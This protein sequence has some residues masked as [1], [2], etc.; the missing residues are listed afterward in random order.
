MKKVKS[1]LC[2]LIAVALM[3]TLFA[4]SKDNP[5]P[6]NNAGSDPGTTGS[7]PPAQQQ[8]QQPDGDDFV[9]LVLGVGGYLGIFLPGVSPTENKPACSGVFDTVFY[10]D[11]VKEEFYSNILSDWHYEDPVTLVMT[12]KTGIMFSNGTEATPADLLFSYTSNNERGSAWFSMLPVDWENCILRDD[13]TVQIKTFAPCPALLEQPAYLISESW[14]REVGWD[15]QEWYY[16]VGSGPYFCYDYLADDHITLRLRD[17][18]WNAANTSFVVD[19]WVIK[20]YPDPTSLDMDFEQGNIDITRVSMQG[21][22]RFL[23]DGGKGIDCR[24]MDMGTISFF[25]MDNAANP[26]FDDIAVRKAIAHA[27]DWE[28]LGYQRIGESMYLPANSFAVP[29]T[30]YNNTSVTKYE[31]DPDLAKSFLNEA[32]YA[33]GE[34][35]INVYTM[36]NEGYK[37]FFVAMQYYLD[38]VGITMNVEYGDVSSALAK[39]VIPGGTEAGVLENGNGALTPNPFNNLDRYTLFF[40]FTYWNDDALQAKIAEALYCPDQ[41]LQVQLYQ[42]LQ[43]EMR[44]NY[45]CFPICL[46]TYV[47]GYKTDVFSSGNIDLYVYTESYCDLAMLGQVAYK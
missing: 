28:Q 26:F 40:L 6:E 22:E 12:L 9:S 34:V 24:L 4:C 43:Q 16:P 41:D 21:Y 15:S 31:Y 25:F 11:G 20:Y 29:G 42:A 37:N 36:D 35:V 18:Y 14:S 8:Q 13:G 27:C 23:R 17:D 7:N 47:M 45:I 1:I 30:I 39:W 44:D 33:P 5:T 2:I 38:Q 19:E 10:Y 32:G 46:C 3:L